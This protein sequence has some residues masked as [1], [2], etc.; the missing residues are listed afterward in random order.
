MGD[1]MKRIIVCVAAFVLLFQAAYTGLVYSQGGGDFYE[2]TF[3][4][5]A[6]GSVH[7]KVKIAIGFGYPSVPFTSP[8][9]QPI[10]NIKAWEAGSGKP[11]DIKETDKGSRV[12]YDIQIPGIQG[13]GYEFYVEYDQ[14]NTVWE[15]NDKAY[16]FLFGW[17]SW[18]KSGHTA[19]VI[20]PKNHELLY[21]DPLD[22][23]DVT[24][25]TGQEYVEFEQT[26][27]EE[28]TFQFEIVFS[29]EG[30]LLLM[31]AENDFRTK[32]YGEAKEKYDEAIEFYEQ[33]DVLYGKNK[34]TF[35]NDLRNRARESET[36]AGEEKAQQDREQAEEKYQEAVTAFNNKE[37]TEAEQLFKEAQTMYKSAGNTGKADE[38]QEY[39]E[40]CAALAGQEEL[41]A[42]ADELFTEGVDLYGQEQYEEAKAKFE[43]ALAKYTELE[44][45]EK[46]TECQEWITTCEKGPEEQ[47]EE[48]GESEE[49]GGGTCTGSS[50][51]IG[52]L[53]GCA[54]VSIFRS[55]SVK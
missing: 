37:Y 44:D 36:K 38:C 46:V 49:N 25:R 39:I 42:E 20:L 48:T 4:P 2:W 55:R 9:F 53:L 15:L 32:K 11:M 12:E 35:L 40:K 33:F 19:T 52:A 29:D 8:I 51:I 34:N 13:G 3:E 6:D 27:E 47:E 30:V 24:T 54:L 45:E 7:V 17:T 1:I 28:E 14:L 16:H 10:K 26:V 22:P 23:V 18:M 41:R 5:K 21:T 31:N 50:L 43:E